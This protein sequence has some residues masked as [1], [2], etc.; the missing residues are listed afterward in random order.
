LAFK[1]VALFLQHKHNT[2][3]AMSVSST[4]DAICKCG[5]T[6]QFKQ[7]WIV[8][9]VNTKLVNNI[10]TSCKQKKPLKM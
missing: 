2:D 9:L 8:F 7:H 10:I 5:N 6:Q 4:V 1:D 3:E